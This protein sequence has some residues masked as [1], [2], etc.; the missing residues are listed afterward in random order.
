MEQEV[1]GEEEESEEEETDEVVAEEEEVV[2]VTEASTKVPRC[3]TQNYNQKE[4][5][6]LCDA[7][8]AISM[9]A[10]IGTDQTKTMFWERITD[11]YN[12]SM[13]V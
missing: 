11:H 5:L 4:D 2:E 8:C 9:D 7:W 3:R 12:K 10:T 6:A 1:T 13:D